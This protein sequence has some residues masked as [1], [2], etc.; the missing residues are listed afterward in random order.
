MENIKIAGK[1]I[2]LNNIEDCEHR[3]F[4]FS[5][6]KKHNARIMISPLCLFI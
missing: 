3:F 5:A 4:H 2:S 6:V 1:I